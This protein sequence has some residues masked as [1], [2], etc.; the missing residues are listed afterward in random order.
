MDQL[1]TAPETFDSM[2]RLA[3]EVIMLRVWRLLVIMG[4]GVIIGGDSTPRREAVERILRF[5]SVRLMAYF[6][7]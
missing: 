2:V 4:I 6:V 3:F 1:P 7:E 5:V